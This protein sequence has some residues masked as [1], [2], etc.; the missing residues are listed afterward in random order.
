VVTTLRKSCVL[1]GSILEPNSG[2]AFLCRF[3]PSRA[4]SDERTIFQIDAAA[5][6]KRASTA[7]R[8]FWRLVDRP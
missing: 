1:A 4:G 6:A 3:G 2:R 8:V 7:S 5:I